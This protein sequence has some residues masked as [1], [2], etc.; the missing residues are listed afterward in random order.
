MDEGEESDEAV[1]AAT[2]AR[3][4]PLPKRR[5]LMKQCWLDLLFAHWPLPPE[6]VASRLPRGL[7]LDTFDGQAWLGIVPFRMSPSRLALG[8]VP[9]APAFGE[10]NV[11]TYV[12]HAGKQGVYFFSLDA[13]SWIG[14]IGARLSFGLPYYHAR[15]NISSEGESVRYATTR[16]FGGR[17]A[18]RAEY[19][20]TGP[21]REAAHGCFDFWLTERYCLF[22][23][24]FGRIW[25]ADI[26]HR[27]WPLQPARCEIATNSM[28]E[29]AGLE[30]PDIPPVLHFSRSQ[31]VLIWPP[32]PSC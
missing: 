28:L 19:A 13:A 8:R 25:R 11:R 17:A 21:V 9:I 12:K 15:M 32:L 24:A 27:P 14:V 29:P 3:S 30:L 4:W 7:E 10:I 6:Q 26:Q 22:T 1:L 20:P 23:R 5:W 18:F 31:C 16:S 2:G